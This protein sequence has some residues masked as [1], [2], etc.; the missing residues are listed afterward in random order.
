[1]SSIIADRRPIELIKDD[2]DGT[3]WTHHDRLTFTEKFKLGIFKKF[4]NAQ[5]LAEDQELKNKLAA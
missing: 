4:A 1:M 5:K 2:V 3:G